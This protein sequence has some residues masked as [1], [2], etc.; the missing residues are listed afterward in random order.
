MLIAN[1]HF[2]IL[3]TVENSF[4]Q[5]AFLRFISYSAR[6]MDNSR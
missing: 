1:I 4:I 3:M 2:V 6:R 5:T